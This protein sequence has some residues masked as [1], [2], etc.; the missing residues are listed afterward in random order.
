MMKT[1]SMTRAA[2]WIGLS[3]V[4]RQDFA[5]YPRESKLNFKMTHGSHRLCKAPGLLTN[6]CK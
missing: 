3:L 1:E 4:V 6:Y 5:P 2:A